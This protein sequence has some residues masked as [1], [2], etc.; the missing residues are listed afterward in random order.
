MKKISS[1]GIS[2]IQ[3]IITV[4]V[5]LI[6]GAS[7]FV[8]IDPTA[9]I[10]VAKDK[11]RQEAVMV[12]SAAISDYTKNNGGALPVLGVI[13]TGKKVLCTVQGGGNLSCD[14]SSLPCLRIAD[15]DFYNDYLPQLPI[16]PDKTANTDTGYYVKKTSDNKLVVGACTNGGSTA[17]ANTSTIDINCSAYAGGHCWIL[18]DALNQNCNTA[19]ADVGLRCVSGVS[20]GPDVDSGGSAYCA[21]AKN[22]SS[23]CSSSCS[24]ATSG[25][26]PYTSDDWA[27][28]WTQDTVVLCNQA[29]G[30]SRFA[31][32][33]CQ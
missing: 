26:P 8:W 23:G 32:C 16:D 33:P 27:D 5:I 11:K 2:M 15:Q 25:Y 20:Y 21:L 12:L 18:D 19:C 28:C 31:I 22:L 14:G 1:Q 24:E 29:P 13:T 17:I 7:V 4:A 10:N 9:R 6:I 30:A 3:L